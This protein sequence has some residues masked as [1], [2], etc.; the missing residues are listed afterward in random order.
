M[1]ERE[2]ID[3]AA[4]SLLLAQGH[5]LQAASAARSE[6]EQEMARGLAEFMGALKALVPLMAQERVEGA[7]AAHDEAGRKVNE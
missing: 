7:G 3:Y 6:F 1:S 2:R 4:R 5:A